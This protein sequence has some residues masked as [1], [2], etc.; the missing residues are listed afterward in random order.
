MSAKFK[1]PMSVQLAS[2]VAVGTIVITSIQLYFL[3]TVPQLGPPGAI[4]LQSPQW[5]T[6][7]E[8]RVALLLLG[9]LAFGMASRGTVRNAARGGLV[10]S[11]ALLVVAI[12]GL[13]GFLNSTSGPFSAERPSPLFFLGTRVSA[14]VFLVWLVLAL[15]KTLRHY[16]AE[17]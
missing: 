16:R 15:R 7:V 17:S 1:L 10:L 12:L 11:S 9:G 14:I 4:V 5:A 8:T 13:W 3:A 6:S 2:L